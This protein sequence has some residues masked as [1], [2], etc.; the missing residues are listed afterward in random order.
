[1][2]DIISVSSRDSDI[3]TEHQVLY[4]DDNLDNWNEGLDRKLTE[5]MHLIF[6]FHNLYSHMEFSIFNLLWVRDFN[7]EVNALIHIIMMIM[8]MT[9]IGINLI[10]M[11]DF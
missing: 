11:I 6:P 7:I 2:E 3:P 10:I 8:V 1:M 9:L 4:L 5:D